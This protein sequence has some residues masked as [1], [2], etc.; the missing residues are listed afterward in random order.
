MPLLWPTLATHTMPSAEM[1]CLFFLFSVKALHHLGYKP[2]GQ[3][4]FFS[5]IIYY[6]NFQFHLSGYYSFFPDSFSQ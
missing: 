3:A 6:L 4:Y 5:S 1:H 2:E